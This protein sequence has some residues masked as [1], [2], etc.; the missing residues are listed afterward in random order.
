MYADKYLNHFLFIVAGRARFATFARY[1][2]NAL[3]RPK[4][5]KTLAALA[6]AFEQLLAKFEAGVVQRVTGA[7]TTQGSTAT[8]V[9]QWKLI[10]AFISQLDVE[11]VKPA[12]HASAPDLLNIYPDKLS[13]LTQAKLDLRLSRFT[14]YTLALEAREVR[15]TK[16]PGI[17]ARQLLNDYAEVADA[18][19]GDEKDVADTISSLGTD[20]TALCGGLWSVHTLA[21]YTFGNEP[22]K[23]ADY[24]D[25]NLLPQH[26]ERPV[27]VPPTPAQP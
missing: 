4:A 24:F 8:E 11:T 18:K 19:Q 17:E 12:Y 5:P 22:G 3:K 1:T 6:P 10:R 21:L 2:L 20:A 27:V 15:I 9:E 23:A 13:G 7:G 16:T 25:Y 14:A 26:S